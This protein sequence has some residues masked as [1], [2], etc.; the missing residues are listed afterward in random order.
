MLNDAAILAQLKEAFQPSE[1]S[2]TITRLQRVPEVWQALHDGDFLRFVLEHPEEIEWT[3]SA[4]ADSCLL[5]KRAN[6]SGSEDSS[7]SHSTQAVSNLFDL[8][9]EAHSLAKQLNHS[10]ADTL[11]T[12]QPSRSCFSQLC[13]AWAHIDETS[14]VIEQILA[15][16][17]RQMTAFLLEVLRAQYADAQMLEIVETHGPA[18]AHYIPELLKDGEKEIALLLADQVKDDLSGS[19]TGDEALLYA[20]A[21]AV[22]GDYEGAHISLSSAWDNA[23]EATAL[24]ADQLAQVARLEGNPS[25]ELEARRQAVE[26]SFSPIRRAALARSLVESDQAYNAYQLTSQAESIEERI[27]FGMAALK[28]GFHSEALSALSQVKNEALQLEYKDTSWLR[29][30]AE[31]LSRSGALA[32]TIETTTYIARLLPQDE[33]IALELAELLE[34]AGDLSAA[35]TQAEFALALN[36]QST[37]AR[38]V[39]AHTLRLDG[40]AAKALGY[41]E[42][43]VQDDPS[44]HFEYCE[45]ALEAQ[46]DD[47]AVEIAT[48]LMGEHPDS[49]MAHSFFAR[50]KHHQGEHEV[51]RAAIE[52]AI[53]LDKS[54]VD[55]WLVLAEILVAT[56]ENDAAG[57][58]L[59][60]AIQIAPENAKAHQ[61]R[62]DWLAA[63]DRFHEAREHSA[64]AV[65]LDPGCASWLVADAR[66]LAKTGD[67]QGARARL[68]QAYAL[69]PK[70]W[71]L[72]LE[73]AR[74]YESSGELEQAVQLIGDAPGEFDDA[75]R[76]DTGR[77]LIKAGVDGNTEALQKGLDHFKRAHPDGETLP[78]HLFWSARANEVL[79][80]YNKSLG[81]YEE[82]LAQ[83]EGLKQHR[84]LE[85]VL[86]YSRVS[87]AQGKPDQV[88]AF[89]QANRDKFPASIDVVSL[90]A[91]AQLANGE[92]KLAYETAREAIALNPVSV[93]AHRL[94]SKTAE[95]I[96]DIRTAIDAEQEILSQQPETGA[97]WRR[98]ARLHFSIKDTASARAHLAKAIHLDRSDAKSLVEL[99]D[100]SAEFDLS[101]T[102][103]R[104][105]KRAGKLAPR[106][107]G[108]QLQ[109]AEVAESSGDFD[110]AYAALMCCLQEKNDDVQLVKRAA[111][112]SSK[113][114]QSGRSIELYERVL[115]KDPE[116]AVSLVALADTFEQMGDPRA[117]LKYYQQ[118]LDLA[119]EE[120][121]ILA[122]IARA[123]LDFEDAGKAR[124]IIERAVHLHPDHVGIQLVQVEAS[125]QA[126]DD[127][128][129]LEIVEKVIAQSAP[130]AH[131][132]AL[133]ALCAVMTGDIE[134]ARA[135]LD[136]A[137]HETHLSS[138]ASAVLL[139]VCAALGEW[140]LYS[141]LL[142]GISGLAKSSV[143][144][145]RLALRALLRAR[146]L[147]WLHTNLLNI[148]VNTPDAK[149]TQAR[150]DSLFEGIPTDA[151]FM[152]SAFEIFDRW[153]IQLESPM[154]EFDATFDQL[155]HTEQQELIQAAAM[156]LIKANRPSKALSL[157][158]SH[159]PLG[160][161]RGYHALLTSIA[162]Q[163]A[164]QPARAKDSAER[165]TRFAETRPSGSYL[166]GSQA[167]AE[168]DMESAITAFNA[169]LA[170]WSNEPAWHA[171]LARIY[172]LGERKEAALP[173]LQQAVELD[174]HDSEYLLAL[175]RAYRN[176]GEWSQAETTYARCLQDSPSAAQVWKEAA[177]VAL[178][179][180]NASQAESWFERACSLAPSDAVC[181]MGSAQA[182]LLMDQPKLAA[183]RAQS[184]YKLAPNEPQ[185]LAGFAEVLAVQGKMEKAIQ[186]YDRALKISGGDPQ[187]QLA[188]SRLLLKSGQYTDAI[189]DINAVIATDD[190]DTDAWALLAEAYEQASQ[191]D[192]ALNAINHA[193]ADSPR[194]G[195]Y[196]LIQ[197][198]MYRKAGQLD[199]AL[200]VLRELEND[201]PDNGSLPAELGNVYEARRETDAA[202]EAYLRAV[203]LNPDDIQSHMSAGI[204]LKGLKSY[205]HAAQMFERVVTARP[206]DPKALHQLAAVRAL[207]LVHGGI[208]TQ[209][210]TT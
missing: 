91:E 138:Q 169:A 189:N 15:A 22:G 30:M 50:A 132:L 104:L 74:S 197:G 72:I 24:V 119:T 83:F 165:A 96:G 17:D 188:R 163:Q 116:D 31:G 133:A 120:P 204:I 99:A 93:D 203:A 18:F 208:E 84:T 148:R 205:E 64:R 129:A 168:S 196:R 86:G 79:K 34:R 39:L 156:G 179:N 190:S 62:A 36:P 48:T 146:D 108:L 128:K 7:S 81:Q 78:D 70:N 35:V 139:R 171:D 23:T 92:G 21:Q 121:A 183:D 122:K 164:D 16:Q 11:E 195:P 115:E 80:E 105:M 57:E 172:M 182:A 186:A 157:L 73:L 25:V 125:L 4:I 5:Y 38:R 54:S 103:L 14:K 51:A 198:R 127:E 9:T 1:L 6:Q 77:I 201:E 178:V 97:N 53:T 90:L 61:A 150:I 176:A 8:A 60:Q 58:T 26:R 102:E 27:A 117:S 89:L 187:V 141:S 69:Q 32:D 95:A 113:A 147:A 118:L 149:A 154:S 159:P 101:G 199:Q 207:Q 162:A 155:S 124:S 45:C 160:T 135:G 181:L 192:E 174:P 46:E 126:G 131:T 12:L 59:L 130:D 44:V 185:V 112:V 56:G 29:W 63:Q 28:Q 76:I 85:A 158:D 166:L 137:L 10:I 49:A 152:N 68:Q 20:Y 75:F 55:P 111:E 191:M 42:Q 175:A 2:A 94:V 177:Q 66:L 193:I 114:G 87:L 153:Q 109:L 100:L 200:K 40:Q 151:R 43:V 13:C 19:S 140:R 210:V 110:T 41:F 170:I 161:Q 37:N 98:M 184:A 142:N 144:D 136:E 47:L 52:K 107:P 3:P 194:S 71:D 206:N 82:Y 106:D 202:L 67:P 33:N 123:Y 209:V 180:G 65:E 145:A 167:H 134:Q 88:I 173:H 143:K